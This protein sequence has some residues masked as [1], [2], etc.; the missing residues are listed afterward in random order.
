[1]EA[2]DF[3]GN[4]PHSISMKP[5][6]WMLT[7][8][9][10]LFSLA[11]LHAEPLV[12]QTNRTDAVNAARNSAKLILLVAG[13]ETCPNCQYMRGTVCETPGIRGIINTNYVCWFCPVD[14]SSEWYVYANGLGGF[15]L[16]LICVI[17]PGN[18]T[19][20]LDQSTSVQSPSDFQTRLKSHLPSAPISTILLGAPPLRMRWQTETQIQYRVL[21]SKDLVHWDFNGTAISGTGSLAQFK[22]PSVTNACFYR[23]MGFR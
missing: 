14:T 7:L 9:C 15:T 17:D 5:L 2:L 11:S 21:S 20:Y 1:V 12:W 18:P 22:D 19:A 4:L 13:R 6:D 8:S 23:V 10:F 3:R 16:P